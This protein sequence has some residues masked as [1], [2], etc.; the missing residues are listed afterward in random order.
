[1]LAAPEYAAFGHGT[2]VAGIIHLVAPQAKIMPLRVFAP[3]GTA[4]NADI[5]RAIYYAVNNGANVINMSFSFSEF[6]PELM[7]AINFATSRGVICASSVGNQGKE[8][9]VYPAAFANVMGVAATTN[10]DKRSEIS[11]FGVD[12]VS[13]AAPGEGIITL[14]P[15]GNY[16]A[17]FGTSFS[18]AFVSGAAA[19]LLEIDRNAVQ[20]HALVALSN[21]KKLSKD[22]GYGRL[23]LYKALANTGSH[24]R[25]NE[26]R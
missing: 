7:R 2:M 3:D 10:E 16:A 14:Y 17:A 19:L 4:S 6:S 8:M 26:K 21:A 11:N 20:Y 1:V 22:L 15:G 18:T 12:V 5:V 24:S 23:D 25:R 13:L 9:L